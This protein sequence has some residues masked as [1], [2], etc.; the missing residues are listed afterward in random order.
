M[1]CEAVAELLP[2]HILGASDE[3]TA[4]AVRQ[5]LRGCA[6]CRSDAAALESG[7]SAFA[8]A[9]HELEPPPPLRERVLTAVAEE[10]AEEPRRSRPLPRRSWIPAAAVVAAVSGLLTWAVAAQFTASDL[11]ADAYE[12]RAFLSA[13]G[14]RDVR[15]AELHP[16]AAGV[17]EG[18]AILYDSNRGR[19]WII[20]FAEVP[21]FD[22]QARAEILARGRRTISLPMRFDEHGNGATWLVTP[23]DISTYRT[24]RVVDADGDLL[25][26]GATGAGD[27][28]DD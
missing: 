12:Y 21:G 18:T 3:V 27:T 15:V 22:G 24:V 13:L 14:G 4:Q 7:V 25:A 6:R 10:A 23:L 2:D 16:R 26:E 1:R 17:V 9:V 28:A 20:V 5:H 19:S 11:R 8:S